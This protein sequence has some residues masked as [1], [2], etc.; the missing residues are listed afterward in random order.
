LGKSPRSTMC[1]GKIG[2]PRLGERKSKSEKSGVRRV[3]GQGKKKR[4]WKKGRRK[5][6]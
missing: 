5:S 6:G 4:G 2:R 3:R 1:P